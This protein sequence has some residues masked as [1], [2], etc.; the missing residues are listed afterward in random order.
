MASGEAIDGDVR[1]HVAACARCRD[2][3]GEISANNAFLVEL[4]ESRTGEASAESSGALQPEDTIPGYAVL[5]EIHRGGQGVVHRAVQTGT[6][7]RV[8]IK[9]LARGAF[10]SERQRQRFQ[11]EIETAARLSHP[12]IVT[13]YETGA[14][15]G[16]RTGYVMEYID[17]QRLG[18]WASGLPRPADGR[19]FS[20]LLR[21]KLAVFERICDAVQHA[22]RHG[23]IHRYL[24]GDNILVDAGDQPH[25]LDFGI[26]KALGGDGPEHASHR[27]HTH[28]G[29]FV[30]TIRYASPEQLAG[31]PD[32][33]DARTDVYTLGVLL[34]ELI[35]GEHPQP[36]SDSVE[37]AIRAIRELEPRRPEA[38]DGRLDTDLGTIALTALAKEP[39]RRYQSALA[40]A[41]DIGR[42]LAGEAIDARRDSTWY[43]LRKAAR[44]HRTP[45]LLGGALAL[46]LVALV[47]GLSVLYG[48]A[49]SRRRETRQA[50][51]ESNLARGRSAMRT[52]STAIAADL[53]WREFLT[54]EAA[55]DRDPRHPGSDRAYWSLLELYARQPCLR[56][57]DAHE[58]AAMGVRFVDGGRS[59]VSIGSDGAVRR[60]DWRTGEP[61]GVLQ[62]DASYLGTLTSDADADR[63][64]W[65]TSDGR[66]TVWDVDDG[67]PIAQWTH[68]GEINSLALSPD[69]T[70]LAWLTRHEF[71]VWDLASDERR[72]VEVDD[73]RLACVAFDPSGERL[74]VLAVGQL[75]VWNSA[76]L[77]RERTLVRRKA[78]GHGLAWSN[79]AQ[80]IFY[81]REH[82]L[83]AWQPDTDAQPVHLGR[84]DANITDIALRP[85]GDRIVAASK[86]HTIRVWNP[87]SGEALR[88]YQG[89]G[90][91]VR[92]IAIHPDGAL[93]AS[94]AKDG[95][96]KLWPLE[97]A[98]AFRPLP[99]HA[100]TV[101]ALMRHP[102]T[103]AI[104]SG[105]GPR[106]RGELHRRALA[107]GFESGQPLH[108][109]GEGLVSAIDVSADGHTLVTASYDGTIRVRD[110]G[111]DALLYPP[112]TN[113]ET[114]NV[115][116]IDLSPDGATIA[117][118]GDDGVVRLWDAATGQPLG[119]LG[120]LGDRVSTIRF[121]A[122][123]DLLA[124]AS[125][126]I[127]SGVFD[128]WDPVERTRLRQLPGHRGGTRILA[129]APEGDTLASAGDD[130]CVRLWNARTGE[131][132]SVLEGHQGDVFALAFGPEG[133]LLASGGRDGL[134]KIWNAS[135]GV[136]L[137]TLETPH[138][139]VFALAFTRDG[140]NLLTGGSSGG[141]HTPL[142]V[143][144]LG[145]CERRIA[146]NLAHH[147]ARLRDEN[148][149]LTRIAEFDRWSR[150][151][152][153]EGRQP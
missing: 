84:H 80:R 44:R 111:D 49:E 90:G 129:F 95:T 71:G 139:M 75:G 50:L 20:E 64:A 91:E 131:Q 47:V 97:N 48:Q 87:Q 152:L 23:V 46:S 18:E 6:G 83:W 141:G 4:R 98:G 63:L 37:A 143:L 148:V 54:G 116:L 55:L 40:L 99:G 33:V 70:R 68:G 11:Q 125:P 107:D 122:A 81:T 29:E 30:G 1:A 126:D 53:L 7:R 92:G 61:L 79:N 118:A 134:V 121:N 85:E 117:S 34:Y 67:A 24:K 60:W 106:D 124:A 14:L 142:A 27:A 135:T 105:G 52:G 25:V 114:W 42:Y 120:A 12:S 31:R 28:T 94:A 51:T 57:I 13:V 22:H 145:R 77:R 130:R 39:D 128:V 32:E 3:L 74:A 2:R 86:G 26:A 100:D 110:A 147:T 66:I 5:G 38:A 151:V 82:D 132:L 35:T 137:L 146:G 17:G 150:R 119:A 109:A 102:T 62:R 115:N 140:R 78:G 59:L 69:G 138:R 123:G 45:A 19:A 16:G 15:P 136:E 36:Q 41:E 103:G 93:L 56:T 21:R 88:L 76:T 89:H 65:V 133:R 149:D 73:R 112:I 10:A 104:Y 108:E 43:V 144:D 153:N 96:I 9:M 101:H 58:G 8:A 72:A 113:Q 127:P